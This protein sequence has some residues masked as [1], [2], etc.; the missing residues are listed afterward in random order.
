MRDRFPVLVDACAT[1]Q[2][3]LASQHERARGRTQPLV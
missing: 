3:G 2:T 1:I